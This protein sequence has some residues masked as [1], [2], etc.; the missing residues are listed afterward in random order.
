VTIDELVLLVNISLEEANVSTCPAG[1]RNG[2]GAV[3]IEEIV[4]GVNDALGACG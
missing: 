3:T 1:D 4:A 2:D